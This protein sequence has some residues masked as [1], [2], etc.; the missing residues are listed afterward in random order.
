MDS[1]LDV[2]GWEDALDRLQGPL[3]ESLARSM[4]VAGGKVLRDEAKLLAPVSD[5]PY[6]PESRGSHVGGTLKEAIYLAYKDSES[7]PAR[8]VYSVSWNAKQAW[9][10]KLIEFGHWQYYKVVRLPDGSY[11]TDKTQPLA[12]P[13]WIAA[14]PFLRPAGDSAAARAQQA[15][16]RRGRERL[17]ELLKSID[18]ELPE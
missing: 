6:N 1:K 17:P 3:R 14:R 7:S 2:S 11:A 16:L 9:W 13:K 18:A 15:M 12:S 5:G 4:A 8:V 10:G